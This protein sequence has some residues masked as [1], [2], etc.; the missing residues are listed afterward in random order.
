QAARTTYSLH[1]L[2]GIAIE[3][4]RAQ[5]ELLP[6]NAQLE[7]RVE[8]RTGELRQKNQQMEEELQ[9]PRELQVALL[10]RKFPT[11]PVGAPTH[12]SALSF[13]SFYFP[14][15]DVSGDFFSV[16]PV[17]EKA[18]G[19]LFCDVIGDGVGSPLIF[20]IIRGAVGEQAKLS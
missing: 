7:D 9:M 19:G 12:E 18:A 13:L 16:F 17:G 14:T 15:G 4:Q 20:G 8:K 1:H 5:E 6:V 3:P 11:I 10:P 2:T